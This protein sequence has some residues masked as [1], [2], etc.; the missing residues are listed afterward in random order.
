[1]HWS[2]PFSCFEATMSPDN[3]A[4][5]SARPRAPVRAAPPLWLAM[6]RGVVGGAVGGFLGYHAFKWLILNH[7]L[8]AM[9]LPGAL[10]GIGCGLASGRKAIALGVLSAIG[11]FLVSVL[12]NWHVLA[13]PS[14][15]FLEQITTLVE[16]HRR[17]TALLILVGVAIAFYF[18]IGRDRR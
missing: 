12:A 17:M 7:G 6:L 18:G 8:Y 5:E 1:M 2:D 11:A 4:A 16:P 9:V 10:V 14:P 15:T 13:E 3:Q